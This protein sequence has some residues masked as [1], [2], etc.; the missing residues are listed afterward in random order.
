VEAVGH[1]GIRHHPC[2]RICAVEGG[3]CLSRGLSAQRALYISA[4]DDPRMAARHAPPAFSFDCLS[5]IPLLCFKVWTISP[6]P[7]QIHLY[8]LFKD[9]VV[10]THTLKLYSSQ[11]RCRHW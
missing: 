10:R 2:L 9:S 4:R 1:D 8:Q 11:V 6:L 7:W 5:R 3:A